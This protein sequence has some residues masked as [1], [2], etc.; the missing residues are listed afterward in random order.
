MKMTFYP[1]AFSLN[2][3]QK[4]QFHKALEVFKTE[5][6]FFVRQKE[7]QESQNFFNKIQNGS[8]FIVFFVFG[9]ASA[10]SQISQSLGLKSKKNIQIVNQID[11][12]FMS[13]MQKQ[14]LA[15]LKKFRFVFISN[16]GKTYESLFYSRF[17]ENLYTKQK[18]SLEG[19]IFVLTQNSKSLLLSW[20][21]KHRA[22]TWYLPK[23]G[24]PGRFS[25]L[26]A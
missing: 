5:Q 20:A 12:D 3:D 13:Y 8:D 4:K 23:E 2:K 6:R 16:S 14:T 25:F 9:G 21:K 15:K 1:P 19:K 11:R 17:I 18:L 7:I 10:S 26:K 22:D 24:V